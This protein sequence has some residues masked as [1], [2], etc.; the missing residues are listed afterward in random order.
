MGSLT[1]HF[2]F[3]I[4]LSKTATAQQWTTL[5][6]RAQDLGYDIA[7]MPDHFGSRFAPMPALMAVASTTQTLRIGTLV[8]AN[9]F[10]HPAGLA[11]EAATMDLLSN[12]RFELGLGTGWLRSD[13]DT[14]GIAMDAFDVR[15][16]RLR[17]SVR[18]IKALLSGQV[19]TYAGTHYRVSELRIEPPTVQQ[20]RPP[21]LIGG[22]SAAI[23]RLAAEEADIISI[24]PSMRGGVRGFHHAAWDS[25]DVA[26]ERK[27]NTLRRLLGPRLDSVELNCNVY[28]TLIQRDV[29]VG[30]QEASATL[31]LEVDEVRK[32]PL[33]LIAS[34]WQEAVETLLFRREKY[35]ISYITIRATQ[36]EGFA[37]VVEALTGK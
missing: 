28:S 32:S 30:L 15:L 37:R 9:D 19:L 1:K 16:Q 22:G 20:P 7:V 27:T 21:I 2:R 6:Q 5:A 36:M 4:T 17:E 24:H 12:G 33:A 29:G 3:G 10:R 11:K 25:T 18:I 13:Y 26:F 35:G 34:T 23:L 31:G 14:T 8:L